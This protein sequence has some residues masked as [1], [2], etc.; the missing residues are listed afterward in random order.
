LFRADQA[1]QVSRVGR[2]EESSMIM[3]S[4]ATTAAPITP[5]K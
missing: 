3:T 1:D 5:V 2:E 4:A